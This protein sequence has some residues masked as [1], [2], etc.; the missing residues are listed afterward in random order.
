MVSDLEIGPGDT[1]YFTEEWTPNLIICLKLN[2]K[3]SSK[4]MNAWQAI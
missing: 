3:I 4:T 1:I 2:I